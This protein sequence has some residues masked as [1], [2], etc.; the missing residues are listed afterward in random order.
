MNNGLF[1]VVLGDTSLANMTA[2]DAPLFMQQ[3]LQLRIWFS[4]GVNGSAALDPPQGLTPSP[5]AIFAN[6]A[7]NAVAATTATTAA[8]AYGVSPNSIGSS[9]IQ[10]GVI[11]AAKIASG[12]VVKSLNGL[13]DNVV[14]AAGN[15][16]TITPSGQTVTIAATGGLSWLLS[17]NAGTTPGA[18]FVGTTDSQPLEFH[19]NGTRALLLQPDANGSGAPNIIGGSPANFVASGTVGAFIGGGG[20]RNYQGKSHTNSVAGDLSVVG[21]GVD[22]A[23]EAEAIWSAIGG[24]ANNTIEPNSIY[25]TIG[26]GFYNTINSGNSGSFIGGGYQNTNLPNSSYATIPGGLYNVA[27]TGA[28]AAGYRA[29]ATNEGA[30]IW[31]DFTPFYDFYSAND[32]E[33]A[34]RCNGGVR[35]VTST[36]MGQNVASVWLGPSGTTWFTI[37]D[38]NAKKDIRPLDCQEVLEK[39]A[40]V[41]VTQWHYKWESSSQ[42][43]NIGPMAQDF[44]GTFYP[45]RDDRSISTLEFDGVEIA[46]IQGLNKKLEERLKEKDA[47]VLAL[48]HRLEGLERRVEL[49]VDEK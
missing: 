26:G 33:F 34:V 14:L 15:N 29:K 8:T 28:F 1:T 20:A 3:N 39:L 6:S 40:R 38:K 48:K 45:G 46:A 42:P 18:E 43:P 47:E 32:N 21:G 5:Y 36:Q 17:G 4:D 24:G 37:S 49:L 13:E 22:N 31:A 19:V 25:S 10:D 27:T 23:I 30:F 9:A 11:A 2:I 7:S 44:V 12:Q 35:F 41:P 16:V